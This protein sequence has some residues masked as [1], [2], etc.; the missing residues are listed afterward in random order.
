M[1]TGETEA[2]SRYGGKVD[3]GNCTK[4]PLAASQTYLGKTFDAL[5]FASVIIFID[6]DASGTLSV[7]FSSDRNNYDLIKTYQID[8]DAAGTGSVHE[9]RRIGRFVR[10]RLTNGPVDQTHLRLQAI[11]N[12]STGF[13]TSTADENISSASDLQLVRVAN[14]AELDLARGLYADKKTFH[15]FSRNGDVPNGSFADLWNQG[16]VVYP[17]PTTSEPL[18][19]AAG[20]DPGDTAAGLGAQSIFIVYLDE[21]GDEQ[22]EEI[23]TNGA[24]ASITTAGLARR[25]VRAWV[26]DAGDRSGE[27]IGDIQIE[28]SVTG[29]VI[30]FIEA[31]L[32][33]S[34]QS[35]FTV[36]RGYSAYIQQISVSVVSKDPADIIFW[37]RKGA[38]TDVAPFGAKRIVEQW[39]QVINVD[40]LTYSSPRK[41][42]EFTDLW[43]EAAGA[44]NN[45]SVRF[46]YDV[47][48]VK[49]DVPLVPE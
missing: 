44:A 27:N 24:A 48:L 14:S 39:E 5:G 22:T 1:P 20:G 26:G 30:G 7:E 45:T 47:I 35:M 4:V 12:D 29:D 28:N 9:L 42:T 31:G 3:L 21:N 25:F 46:D 6:T 43:A 41:F 13:L 37:Q 15:R 33:Q 32:G 49:G 18:R 16:T 40:H 17:W 34:A 11:F 8:I 23:P 36:P 10:V 38:Y 2:L 19:I